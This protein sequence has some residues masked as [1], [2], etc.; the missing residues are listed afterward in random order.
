[1]LLAAVEKYGPCTASALFDDLCRDMGLSAERWRYNELWITLV[2]LLNAGLVV[3]VPS[4]EL[5]EAGR[6]VLAAAAVPPAKTSMP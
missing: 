1:M 4:V 2:E 3:G 5:T 6:T